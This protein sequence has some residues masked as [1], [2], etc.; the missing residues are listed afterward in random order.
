MN[1]FFKG[2]SIN[3]FVKKRKISTF[4]QDIFIYPLF[5]AI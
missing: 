1:V 3:I 2:K 5:L 4:L